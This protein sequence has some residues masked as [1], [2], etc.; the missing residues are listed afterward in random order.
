MIILK[1]TSESLTITTTTAAALDYSVSYVDITTSS[2]TPS[3]SEGKI[4]SAT[5]TTVLSAPAA[6]T[7]RQVKLITITN[8]DASLSAPFTVFK[9]IT[10]T[11]YQIASDITLSVG[12]TLQYNDGQGWVY[13]SSTGTIK[14]NMLASGASNAIQYNSGGLLSGDSALTWDPATDTMTFG[15]ADTGILLNG[16]TNEPTA[17]AANYGRLY[18]KSIAG[19]ILPKWVGP[20]GYD[21][22]LQANIGVNNVRVWRGG[23]TTTAATFASTTGSM[24]YTGASPTAPTIPALATTNS[25][26]QTYRSTISTGTTAGALAYIRGNS[27][28]LVRGG[29][30]GIGGFTVIH[31]FAL[32][33][34]L[35]AGLR[36]FAGIVD[37]AA[38]PTNVDPTTTTAPGGV[39]MAIAANSGNWQLVHNI[40]G[41]GR[42]AIDLGASFAV[43]N[44]S[45][46]EIILFA[47]TNGST[48]G[49]RATNLST[50]ATTSGTLSTNIPASTTFL[51]PSVWV[52]NNAT[53]AAQTLDFISTYVETDF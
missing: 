37:V 11:S 52:T 25:L 14:S 41:T 35:Q 23:A 40:T 27:L 26:T 17:P 43:N 3:T 5:T 53:A 1:A 13:Y 31:R 2:F 21:Y 24:P 9:L 20:S 4:T 6:S 8:A 34:T 45:L 29:G 48:I 47:A 15:G 38:N 7:Q 19:R 36:A 12:E 22:P 30:A 10:A 44:T 49:Y 46:L 51:A 50:A 39:G 16:V 18:A 28:A 33:G 32:S 42:T